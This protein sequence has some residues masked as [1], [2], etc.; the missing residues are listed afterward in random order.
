MPFDCG[1]ESQV[2]PTVLLIEDESQIRRYLRTVLNSEG[3]SLLEAATA[4]D[5]LQMASEM[6]PDVVILDLGLPDIDGLE[7]ARRLR[8]WTGV[9][10]IILSARDGEKDKITAL[11]AGADDYLTKPFGS[12]ELMARIRVALRNAA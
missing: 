12:G 2:K 11:D 8:E 10:I 9:P 1:Q 6:R 4:K 3:F 5:G 7:V